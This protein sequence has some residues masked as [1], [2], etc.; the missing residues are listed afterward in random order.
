MRRRYKIYESVI[1]STSLMSHP[2][3][4]TRMEEYESE[5]VRRFDPKP[6]GLVC[7]YLTMSLILSRLFFSNSDRVM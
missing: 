4:R 3:E 2:D 6:E 1:L 7:K 5:V